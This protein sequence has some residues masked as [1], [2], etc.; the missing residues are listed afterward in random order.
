MSIF[1]FI[2]SNGGLCVADLIGSWGDQPKKLHPLERI[3][4][5]Y[6][7]QP[8]EMGEPAKAAGLSAAS[9]PFWAIILHFKYF[10]RSNTQIR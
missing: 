8:V 7:G 1:L 4:V 10:A 3:G 2:N 9:E 5:R 6:F